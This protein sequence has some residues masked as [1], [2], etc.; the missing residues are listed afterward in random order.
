MKPAKYNASKRRRVVL[1]ALQSDLETGMLR[2]N[3][4]RTEIPLTPAQVGR[5]TKE[6]NILKAKI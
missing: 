4:I 5:I 6:I 1:E 3:C 2:Q